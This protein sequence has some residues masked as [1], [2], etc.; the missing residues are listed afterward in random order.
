MK[1]TYDVVVVGSG[2]GGAITACRLAQAGRSVCILERSRRWDKTD[3][4]RSPGEVAKS[5]WQDGGSYGFLEYKAFK[6]IDVIQGCGVG[7]GSLHYFNV[8]LRTPPDIF[9]QKVWPPEITRAVLDPYYDLAEEMLESQRL[10]P[11]EGREQ[12]LR[13]AGAGLV[14]HQLAHVEVCPLRVGLIQTDERHEQEV[15]ALLP[16]PVQPRLKGER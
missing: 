1:P 10:T 5:F 16:V 6:R 4:P 2:F 14:P 9:A 3:F 11:P 12:P 13:T 7:G 15:A 8:H